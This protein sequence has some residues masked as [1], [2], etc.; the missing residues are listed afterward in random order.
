MDRPPV[1][2]SNINALKKP[3]ELLANIHARLPELTALLEEMS[4]HWGYEDPIYRFYHQSFKVYGLQKETLKIV[5]ALRSIAPAGTI[6][7]AMFEEIIK[8]R[9]ERGEVR[10]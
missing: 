6:F 2:S 9:S 5:D 4:S 1:R 3:S 10:G 7:T 8:A